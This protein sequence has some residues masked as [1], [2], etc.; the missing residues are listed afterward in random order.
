MTV[1]SLE[2]VELMYCCR[3]VCA[4]SLEW[5]GFNDVLVM[6][7]IDGIELF[8]QM[9]CKIVGITRVICCFW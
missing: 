4:C 8:L 7:I 1:L 2:Y 9:L 3:I 5:C 6:I